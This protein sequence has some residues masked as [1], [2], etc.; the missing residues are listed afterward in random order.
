[1]GH[2]AVRL[3]QEVPSGQLWPL[4]VDCALRDASTRGICIGLGRM[5]E[6]GSPSRLSQGCKRG[7]EES[8]EQPLDP[9]GRARLL[10][11]AVLLQ[12]DCIGR[13]SRSQLSPWLRACPALRWPDSYPHSPC[14]TLLSLARSQSWGR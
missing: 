3:L 2:V 12:R 4:C 1:M 9:Q 6:V 5:T 10:K 11:E 8:G 14:M 7:S 13:V